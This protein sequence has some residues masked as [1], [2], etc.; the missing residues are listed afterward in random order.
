MNPDQTPFRDD[1]NRLTELLE[2]RS[3]PVALP[4]CDTPPGGLPR[5]SQAGPL[6]CTYWKR[7]AQGESF[8]TAGAEGDAGLRGRPTCAA[9]PAALRSG[10]GVASLGCI[11][12]RVY[13]ELAD[14]ELYYAL[15]GSH[16]HG[17]T[18]RLSV[19]LSANATLEGYHR[20]RKAQ[21]RS[22]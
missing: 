15:P 14:D 19:I 11:G 20:D 17:V 5:V 21:L 6:S 18:E 3:A 16:L 10:G 2:L 9:I 12:N 22:A 1:A 13:T 7:A 4:F 8:Y